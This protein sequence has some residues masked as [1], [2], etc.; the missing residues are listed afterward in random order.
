MSTVARRCIVCVLPGLQNRAD[1]ADVQVSAST[2]SLVYVDSNLYCK[3]G[4][5]NA[6][7]LSDAGSRNSYYKFFCLKCCSVA[8]ACRKGRKKKNRF[9][10]N[11]TLFRLS[12]L[13]VDPTAIMANPPFPKCR[14]S[15]SVDWRV[16]Q[17]MEK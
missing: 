10:K 14:A 6:L 12:A 13:R 4:K 2:C 9:A 11:E 16:L 3:G 1:L 7:L 5:I 8:F 15:K 17:S